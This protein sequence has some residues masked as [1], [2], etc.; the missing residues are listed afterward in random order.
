MKI[1]KS[2]V[3]VLR[4]IEAVRHALR[5]MQAEPAPKEAP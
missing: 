3:T 2:T 4:I 5:S 1:E